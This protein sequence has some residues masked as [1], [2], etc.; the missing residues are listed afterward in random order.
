MPAY[1]E[2]DSIVSAVDDVIHNV[3]SIVHDA[4]LL[5]INDGS[6]DQTGMILD[7]IAKQDSRIVPIHQKNA[8]HGGA[9][10]AGIEQ[11]SGEYL[12]L[13]DSD[14][15]IP[16]NHFTEF[17][18]QLQTENTDAVFGIRTQRDDPRTRIFLTKI[19]RGIV[20]ASFFVNLKDANIPFKL[21]NRNLWLTL[22]PYLSNRTLAPSLFL[23]II[24]AKSGYNIKN[25][26]ITH[27]RRQTGTVSIKH[28][29]L[30]RFCMKAFFQLVLLRWD[31][32]CK[33]PKK[34]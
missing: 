9:L 17:W 29:R 12:F 2:E 30:F 18:H 19:I 1:N 5:V 21:L 28:W 10:M 16:L 22:Q 11:A 23:A 4:E 8:G 6:R 15:Q 32:I 31:L 3:F 7:D 14:R 13:I 33:P 27:S 34:Y 20:S 25:I 26:P 24:S